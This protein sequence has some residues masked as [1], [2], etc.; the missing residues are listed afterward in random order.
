M[1]RLK[2]SFL[3]AALIAFI[4]LFPTLANFYAEYL[5]FSEVGYT[6][7]FLT[8]LKTK[9]ALGALG[10]VVF[11]PIALLNFRKAAKNA[12]GSD[13]F[14]GIALGIAVLF[15]L[16][17]GFVTSFAW[18][19]YL[20]FGAQ[21]AFGIADPIFSKDIGFYIFSLPFY[22]YL[23]NMLLVGFVIIGLGTVGFYMFMG[24]ALT[25]DEESGTYR[26]EMP[27]LNWDYVTHVLVLGSVILFL[28]GVGNLLNRYSIL[29]SERGAVYGA[30]YTDINVQLPL[31]TTL[32][33]LFFVASIA[34]L[35]AA[36]TYDIKWSFIAIVLLFFVGFVGNS[37]AGFLQQYKVTPDE[38]NLEEPYLAHN[39]KFT[40]AAYDL[41]DTEVVKFPANTNLTI[42]DIEA[43]SQTIDNVRLWDWKPLRRTYEQLQLIRTYYDFS[44]VDIDRYQIN[45]DYKQVMLSPRELNP[46]LLPQKTWVNE[47]LVYTHGY[48]IAM[49]PVRYVSPE[50]LPLFYVKDIPPKSDFFDIGRPEIYYGERA[51]SYIIVNS[52]TEEFDYSRGDAAEGEADEVYTKY[53]GVGGIELSSA[54]RRA[55][56]AFRFNTLKLFVSDSVTNKSRIMMHRNIEDR[57]NTIAPF[58]K[59]DRDPYIVTSGGRLYWIIDAY[60]VSDRYPYSEPTGSINYIRNPVKVVIDAYSGETNFYVIEDEPLINVYS[61]IFPDLFKPFSEMPDDLKKHV[62]YPEDLFSIQAS[63]YLVYHMKKT[64]IFYNKEDQWEVPQEL[65]EGNR[66]TMEPYYLITRLPGEDHV[67][68]ILLLP[69]TPRSKPNMVAWMAARGDQEYYGEKVVYEFP[70]N[71]LIFGPIQIE[72]R[73]DQDP[74]ISQDFTLWSQSGS[75]VIR[76]NLLV[77]PIEGSLLYVEPVYLSSDQPDALPELKRVIVA[78]GDTLTM[79]DTLEESL[80]VVF[81]AAAPDIK[82]TPPAETEPGDETQTDLPAQALEHYKKAQEYLKDGDWSA[83]GEELDKLEAILNQLNT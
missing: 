48:G 13:S 59:Y 52:N 32:A 69:F 56:M 68:F 41:E 63:K 67:E 64:R 47:H 46:E 23:K 14:N 27:S 38:Y 53:A 19:T 65:Y 78:F 25:S 40:R 72:A 58:L 28:M 45:E 20:R 24:G 62:R 1:A 57:V 73:I 83:Y 3:L 26:F 11:F 10:A 4:M 71:K 39:I 43:N 12:M 36:R 22:V 30:G 76:G 6:S 70:K 34:T 74:D 37:S 5:W 33:A 16:F 49:S 77:I 50:G 66:I 80:A 54:F 31:I 75:K 82:P 2:L 61:K 9:I 7:V 79:Q 35:L 17:M 81:G 44:D 60:T 15:A 8:I 55:I 18:D 51:T 42:T 21:A 29:Y